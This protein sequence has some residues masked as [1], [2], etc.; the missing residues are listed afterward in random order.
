MAKLNKTD[1]AMFD[2]LMRM[3]KKNPDDTGIVGRLEDFAAA[4]DDKYGEHVIEIDGFFK[5]GM[6]KQINK[7]LKAL[8]K[9]APAAVKNMGYKKG[10][11]TKMQMGGMMPMQEQKI[12][13][14]TGLTMK[15]GGMTDMRKTGMFYGGMANRKM[16]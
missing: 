4:M 9:V 14:T 5:G 2:R 11:I 13:P 7:G 1:R 16:K 3:L 12:N 8:K 10:G 6:P 15:K